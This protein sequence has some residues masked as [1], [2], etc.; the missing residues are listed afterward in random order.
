MNLINA[1]LVNLYHICH[2]EMWL[3]HHGIRMEHT[4]EVVYEG[5]LIGETT[6]N[7]RAVSN[8]QVELDGVKIDYYDP[9]T[10]TVHETKKSD[11]ME[12]AHVAQVKYYL[13]ILNRNGINGAQGLIE[14]PRLRERT[15]VEFDPENDGAEVESWLADIGRILGQ[16][17][18]PPVLNKPV[19]KR[20]SYYDFCYSGEE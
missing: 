3:H 17:Q 18:C 2:R 14:Y 4:S 16:E 7:E 8:R 19:C 12:G 15:R 5:K 13:Y 11:K 10:K 1:T 20:C 6:Y 9:K